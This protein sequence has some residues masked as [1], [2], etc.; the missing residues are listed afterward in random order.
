M[1]NIKD[2]GTHSSADLA[3]SSAIGGVIGGNKK[4]QDRYNVEIGSAGGNKNVKNPSEDGGLW[5]GISS[6]FG[7]IFGSQTKD[8]GGWGGTSVLDSI[9]TAANIWLGYKQY[10][11]QQEQFKFKKNAWNKQWEDALDTKHRRLN[12]MRLNDR[13]TS[14]TTDE[15]RR[16]LINEYDTGKDLSGTGGNR[17]N[18]PSQRIVQSTKPR[19]NLSTMS[20]FSKNMNRNVEPRTTRN[21]NKNKIA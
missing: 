11:Q 8:G 14:K 12:E 3:N 7:S 18:Y 21:V 19:Q 17:V 16:R 15:E 4:A 9:G 5:S 2:I 1:S 6:A 10:K 20:A 13:I